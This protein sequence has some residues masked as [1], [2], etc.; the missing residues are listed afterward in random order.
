MRVRLLATV[1]VAASAGT[2]GAEVRLPKVLSD[3]A[4][5]QRERPIH[6]WGWA[7]PAA[8]LRASFHGQT[9]QAI[10]DAR[11]MWS[12]YLQPEH[13]GGPYA[14]KISGDGADVVV[15][16]L[17]IGDVWIASGQSNMEFPLQGFGPTTP[18]KDQEKE[19]AAGTNPKLRLLIVDKKS[20]DTPVNDI[21]RGWSQCT[22]ETARNFSAVAYFFGREIAAKED[23]PVGLVDA[24]WGGTPADSWVSMNTLGTNAQLLP[25]FA[26]RALFAD[27]QTD[28]E[29][30]QAE[31]K[32]EDD[33]AKSKGQPEPRHSWHPFEMSWLPAGLYN[34]MIAPLTPMSVRG[35]VW[36]QGESN[37]TSER[38]PYYEAL[39][40]ALIGDWRVHFAQGR[41]PFLFVQI[42]SFNSPGEEWGTIRDAQRRV[43][44]VDGTA[45]AVSLDVGTADNVHPPDKQTIGN[46][47]AL[48]AR[49]I[50]YGESTHY[51]GPTFREAT[52]E[53]TPDGETA[54]RVWFDHAA[55]L[56]FH[57]HA[58]TGF[59]LAGA[60]HRFVLAN[61]TVQGA[62]VLVKSASVPHPLYV[63]F[64]WNSVVENSLYN[65]D[66]L[67][68]S[69]FTSEPSPLHR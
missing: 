48:A 24:T 54:M 47:L 60:D 55:G 63:R 7:T 21:A 57:G 51:E 16:D 5:L 11:G 38:A 40:R 10:A 59:E 61:A 36:Y 41:L 26:E 42:S 35:F 37:S 64:A 52:T 19:I 22:P 17:L 67:P 56:S 44:D 34:G 20:S 27:Q 1:L 15:S 46:R 3:H 58:A 28:L 8:H 30:T 49:N 2:A 14:L 69:T 50:V 13:A 39:F 32:H 31:E 4:V 33:E 25:A 43:L 53:L 18:L 68:A 6:V 23:V 9:V 66:G 65:N 29:A 62:T 12:V 45:M